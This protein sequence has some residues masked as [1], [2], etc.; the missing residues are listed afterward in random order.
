MDTTLSDPL[1]DRL[2]DGRYAI[3]ARLARGGMASV[4]LAT[5]VRLERRVAVK[6]MHPA[7]AEDP[8]FVARFNREAR[9]AARL[10]HPDAVSVYD[11]GSDD[12]H[13]FLV[14]EFVAG[15]T[16]REVLRQ[17]G[18]LSPGEAV[19]VMD[20]VL[21]A[22]AAAHAAGLVHRDVKPENVLV[23][24]D[25]RVKVADFGLARAITGSTLTTDD[26]VLLGTAA[27][28]APEQVRDGA[29]DAR[30]DV[31][32]A[33]VMLFELLTGT[34]PY[35]GD[36]P[37]AVAY[38]HMSDDVPAPSS[39]ARGIPAE[40]DAL[41][42]DATARDP[43][44][45]PADGGVLHRRLEE[46]RDRLGL[47]AA[48]PAPATDLTVQVPRAG[49]TGAATTSGTQT[50]TALPPAPPAGGDDARRPRRRWPFVL[51]L[52]V[53]LAAVAGVAGWWLAAGRY[54]HA[55]SLL[56]LTAQ[57][58]EQKL[59]A[60]GLHWRFLPRV[61]SDS[62]R[63][64]LVAVQTPKAG[65]RVGNGATVALRLSK[66]PE[67]VPV[68]DVSGKTVKQARAA[69]A[70]VH[71]TVD[72]KKSAYSDTV[73]AGHV[74]RTEPSSGTRLHVD[75]GVTLVVSK[76][77]RPVRVPDVTGMPLNKAE[78]QLTRAGFTLGPITRHYN[79]SI[80]DG[81]VIATSPGG[82]ALVAPGATVSIDVSKGPHLYQVPD[83]TGMKIGDA[84]KAIQ[85]AGFKADPKQIFPAGPGKVVRETPT[86]MQPR[87]TTIELDYF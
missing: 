41:V 58:A 68:P 42:A 56:G 8:E 39:R 49:A 20:H 11:Q 15:S 64:D 23:T 32:S 18:K 37:M 86:G 47:H 54:T 16:L 22:L 70:A 85:N 77:V 50:T 80:R 24:A 69:L 1:V 76:G 65:E 10:S 14:M 66:G 38:R 35:Q 61:Y 73:A 12:G 60:E 4:Y 81:S 21:A 46:V 9:A 33:G 57:Q 48:V 7:L 31:Y 67:Q 78:Q 51:A 87:G 43:H 71:L 74:I 44:R 34:P 45:R 40:L 17:R 3:E 84:I 28:L 59:H 13:V 5:D 52:V 6:V 82:N 63:E 26:S 72:K 79:D 2:L 27:Y 53:L 62:I 25:G 29:A 55:P 75:T 30:S 19:A 36:T 83:V